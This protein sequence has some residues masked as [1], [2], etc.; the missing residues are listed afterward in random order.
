MHSDER[1]KRIQKESLK[2]VSVIDKEFNLNDKELD[3]VIK[4]IWG[5]LNKVLDKRYNEVK[6]R[7]MIHPDIE[8]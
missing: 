7:H 5:G 3:L 6:N 8:Y 1:L 2:L 4:G